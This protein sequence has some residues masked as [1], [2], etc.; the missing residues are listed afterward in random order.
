MYALLCYF[1]KEWLC[2]GLSYNVE[3]HGREIHCII[4]D[5]GRE[6]AFLDIPL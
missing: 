3:G 1:E 4:C 6:L 5:F 2:G